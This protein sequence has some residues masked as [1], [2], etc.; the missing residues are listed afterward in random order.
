MF[1]I[2]AEGID[3]LCATKIVIKVHG[4]SKCWCTMDKVSDKKVQRRTSHKKEGYIYSFGH[5]AIS[6]LMP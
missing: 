1:I 2:T 4:R 5:S 6:I 3:I